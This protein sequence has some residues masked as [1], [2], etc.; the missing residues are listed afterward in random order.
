MQMVLNTPG[1]A[2]KTRDGAFEV[3]AGEERR[4]VSPQQ[5]E[6]IAV[7]APCLISSSA[8]ELA[9]EYDLSIYFFN[10]IGDA[11]GCLR[12]PYFESIATLRR[13]QVYFSDSPQ[14]GN[15]VIL[16]FRLKT[17]H[18]IDVLQYLANRRPSLLENYQRIITQLQDGIPELDLLKDQSTDFVGNKL[19]GWEGN[20]AKLYW[21]A[22]SE[23]MPEPWKFKGRS[24]RPAED[25]FNAM[26]NYL[27]GM[28]YTI[29]EQ[30]I[31]AAGLDP[32]LGIL[33]SDEYDRPTLAFDLIEP[34]RPWVDQLLVEQ[35]L[36]D[37]IKLEF[38]DQVY[39]GWR[40]NAAGKKFIIPTFNSWLEEKCRMDGKQFSRKGHIYRYA[41]ELAQLIQNTAYDPGKL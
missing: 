15:W 20:Q 17:A 38:F 5:L 19:M 6:S 3:A 33:H 35:F 26:L 34:F 11:V 30:A 31:F 40:L 2:L 37:Q 24:R 25:G 7:T 1:L 23:G 13:K 28:M 39:Q 12:S 29:V 14:G 27:Y 41:A 22:V 4:I 18:Q 32:H 8:I 10:E 9:I 16:L 21:S 36:A